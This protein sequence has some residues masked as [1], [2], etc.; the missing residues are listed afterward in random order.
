MTRPLHKISAQDLL[1]E[2]RYT[3]SLHKISVQD[4][5]KRS[6]SN[7]TVQET[8]VQDPWRRRLSRVRVRNLHSGSPP[9]QDPARDLF[10][11]SLYKISFRDDQI[12]RRD[13]F[14]EI[15]VQGLSVEDPRGRSPSKILGRDLP[16]Y[17]YMY[18]YIYLYPLN[19]I[20]ERHLRQEGGAG[21]VKTCAALQPQGPEAHQIERGL[22]KSSCNTHEVLK[23]LHLR[24]SNQQRATQDAQMQS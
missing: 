16:L 21:H 15:S 4:P 17:I 3:R 14:T 24:K 18:I 5:R 7:I 10:A 20:P 22:R 11:R 6:T 12:S 8:S 1:V 13:L 23:G 19:K 2:D 9:A